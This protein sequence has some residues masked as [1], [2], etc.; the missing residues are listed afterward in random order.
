MRTGWHADRDDLAR[1]LKCSRIC[2]SSTKASGSS[3]CMGHYS[4]LLLRTFRCGACWQISRTIR[5]CDVNRE[6]ARD[7]WGSDLRDNG[8][9]T[10]SFAGLGRTMTFEAL[11][12]GCSVASSR[13]GHRWTYMEWPQVLLVGG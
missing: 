2:G 13:G 8:A 10:L 5:H 9:Q 6:V 11:R 4:D 12:F 7:N 3:A 1:T